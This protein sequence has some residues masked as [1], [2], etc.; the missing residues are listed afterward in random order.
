MI[1]TN[2]SIIN[3]KKWTVIYKNKKK[4]N[5][6]WKYK[7]K[8]L[9]NSKTSAVVTQDMEVNLKYSWITQKIIW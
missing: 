9:G 3:K 1:K 2:K 7:K 5:E 4:F 6:L 8:T